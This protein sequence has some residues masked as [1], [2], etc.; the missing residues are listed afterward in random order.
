M[1]VAYLTINPAYNDGV[2]DLDF[3]NAQP[4]LYEDE[5]LR[6]VRFDEPLITRVDGR[7]S[8]GKLKAVVLKPGALADPARAEVLN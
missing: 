3:L 7:R 5:Y 6:H 2:Y 8:D 1:R 4:A